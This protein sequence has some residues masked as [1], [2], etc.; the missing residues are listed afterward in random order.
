MLTI[1]MSE[2]PNKS[3]DNN[4]LI[5]GIGSPVPSAWTENI[6]PFTPNNNN[7]HHHHGER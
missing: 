6:S 7:H 3:D 2:N 5:K 1:L 4:I